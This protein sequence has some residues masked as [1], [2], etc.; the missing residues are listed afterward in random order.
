MHNKK[1]TPLLNLLKNCI[2]A[3]W[4]PS[5]IVYKRWMHFLFVF[6]KFLI[7]GLPNPFANCLFLKL[8]PVLLIVLETDLSA[9]KVDFS[10]KNL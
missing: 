1:K 8:I 7:V 10:S 5:N 4:G 9:M 6:F 3:K 2:S